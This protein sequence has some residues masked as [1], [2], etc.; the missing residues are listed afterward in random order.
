MKILF[1][2][3]KPD[4]LTELGHLDTDSLLSTWLFGYSIR[5]WLKVYKR[6]KIKV[7]IKD[8][9]S[10]PQASFNLYGLTK[11]AYTINYRI[12]KEEAMELDDL[13]R[14][15]KVPK[16]KV[17]KTLCTLMNKEARKFLLFVCSTKDLTSIQ[18]LELVHD[19]L[20][21]Y[22]PS[23]PVTARLET[24]YSLV[25]YVDRSIDKILQVKPKLNKKEKAILASILDKT[26]KW[27]ALQYN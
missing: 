10:Y 9:V 5:K 12:D 14:T 27:H 1:S 7:N 20:G 19:I 4:G 26:A 13:F 16:R 11:L 25:N 8:I 17:L 23:V 22:D 18:Y 24:L 6:K 15:S 2:I 21:R 3:T